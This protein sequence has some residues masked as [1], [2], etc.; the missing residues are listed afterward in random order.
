MSVH[1]HVLNMYDVI[2]VDY[3]IIILLG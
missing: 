1:I 3:D 2:L